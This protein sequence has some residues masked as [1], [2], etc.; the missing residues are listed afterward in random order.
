MYNHIG[1]KIKGLAKFIA[2]VG[3]IFSVLGG[4]LMMATGEAAG[5]IGGIAVALLGILF[6]WIGGFLLY[7]YG[8]LIDNTD[9]I[10]QNMQSFRG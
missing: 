3:I 10:V 8:Q 6:S 5:I 7:G 2:W 9:I 1:A 4:V